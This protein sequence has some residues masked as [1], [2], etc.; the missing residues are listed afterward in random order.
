MDSFAWIFAYSNGII[1]ICHVP[2]VYAGN[3]IWQPNIINLKKILIVYVFQIA[4]VV[5][6]N[7]LF[8]R[9]SM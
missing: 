2:N 4:E 9:D 7:D 5:K 3:E 1:Y 8:A 6:L